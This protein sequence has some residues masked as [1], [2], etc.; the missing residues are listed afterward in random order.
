MRTAPPYDVLRRT[1]RRA[2]RPSGWALPRGSD[3]EHYFSPLG[4]G[5]HRSACGTAY[6][7]GSKEV[8]PDSD[9]RGPSDCAV[10][11]QLLTEKGVRDDCNR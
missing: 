4:G 10:C 1:T 3:L 9:R 6:Y 8:T 7:S 11:R 5:P 2:R